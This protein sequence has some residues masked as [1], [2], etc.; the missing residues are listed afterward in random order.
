MDYSRYRIHLDDVQAGRDV[1][2]TLM[3]RNIP[4]CFTQDQMLDIFNSFV[5]DEYDF[6][7]MPVDFKTNCNLGFGYIS[8]L[9]T[10]SVLKVYYK[11]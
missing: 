8:M 2:L 9:S 11:V 6:F 1:R 4:N 3:I 7:Y 10:E 5:K